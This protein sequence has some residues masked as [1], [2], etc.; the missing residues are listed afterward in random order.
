MTIAYHQ[1]PII[2]GEDEHEAL[3]ELAKVLQKAV[4]EHQDHLEITG[5][6]GTKV[7]LPGSALTA[8]YRLVPQLLHGN[9]VDIISFQ[10]QLTT[11]EAADI[12][13]VS[14]PYLIKLLE[15]GELPFSKV[16]TH[17]RIQFEDLMEYKKK[18]DVERRKLLA[19]ITQLSQEMGLYD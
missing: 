5:P 14:R 19:E 15:A 3:C 9:V 2:A 7:E 18:R 8:L 10:K 11:Q 16:G 6:E 1:N 12:L 17:R 4:A 13:N